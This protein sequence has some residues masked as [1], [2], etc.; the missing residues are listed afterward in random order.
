MS[1]PAAPAAASARLRGTGLSARVG[2]RTLFE[3]L[4]VEFGAGDVVALTG[5]NGAGK[6]T[7]LRLLLGLERP[8]AGRVERGAGVR[9]GY[10]PQLDPGE[11]GLPF[12]AATIV[13]QGARPRG[14][15][16][17]AGA[18]GLGRAVRAA[19]A[20]AGFRPPASRR[21]TRLSGGERRRVLLARAL[22][23]EPDLLALDEPTSGVDAAG[24][25]EVL[26]LVLGLARSRGTSVAWVAHGVAR[27]ESAASRVI[28]LG[29]PS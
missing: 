12:P 9:V 15:G 26:D 8:A 7:L 6:S 17:A 3:G 5:A 24:E 25:A 10:V 29:A 18:G 22:V 11:E 1:E 16:G 20:L 28:R 23:G 27:L 19:L 2:G 4:D 13:A 14:R 21:Y